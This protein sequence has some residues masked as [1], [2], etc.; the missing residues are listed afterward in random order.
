MTRELVSSA[1]LANDKTRIVRYFR[2]RGQESITDLRREIGTRQH[3]ELASAI[4]RAVQDSTRGVLRSIVDSAAEGR[5]SQDQRIGALLTA[6]YSSYI[7]MIE[8]RN[9]VWPYEYMAFSRRVGELWEGFVRC[10]FDNAPSGLNYFVPPLFSDV[11]SSLR[12]EIQQ[13]IASLPINDQQKRELVEYYNKVW[14]LVDSGEINL[15]LDLHFEVANTRYNVDLKSGFG[16]NEK[17]NTNRLLMVA[18]IYRNVYPDYKNILLVRA[19][20]DE[21]NHYFRTLRDSTVWEAF[22]GAAA[23][24]KMREYTGY[25]IRR[26]IDNNVSWEGDLDDATATHLRDN[27]LLGYLNW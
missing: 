27:Q 24:E 2:E 19:G 11:S 13:Y 5:W 4:N 1:A 9:E 21:N 17:G 16:S 14:S 3:K 8:L 12:N 18:S 20:E 26:W 22:C 25:N 6:T 15:E 7:A 23:Y 10:L